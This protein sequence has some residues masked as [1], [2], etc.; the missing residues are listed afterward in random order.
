MPRCR[1]K[2]QR[3]HYEL[4]T[5]EK[6]QV[7]TFISRADER[8]TFRDISS[9]RARLGRRY[10]T[11][12]KRVDGHMTGRAMIHAVGHILALF[13]IELEKLS[14]YRFFSKFPSLTRSFQRELMLCRRARHYRSAAKN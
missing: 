4:I 11:C 5:R 1:R 14:G 2:L 9:C 3:R 13:R 10:F 6:R 7:I 12:R 8:A